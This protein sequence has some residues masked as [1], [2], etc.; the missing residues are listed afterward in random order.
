ML[1]S[2]RTEKVGRILHTMG[3]FIEKYAK[4]MTEHF[5]DAQ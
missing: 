2:E 1:A 4:M 5:G 3:T